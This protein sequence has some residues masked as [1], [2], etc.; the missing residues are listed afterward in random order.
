V[1]I[2]GSGSGGGIMAEQL[3]TAGFTVLV[4]EKGGYFQPHEFARW[5]ESEAMVNLYEKGG[6]SSSED[7]SVIVLAG[8]C[9]GG[10]TTVNWT[11][12]FRTPDVVQQDWANKGLSQFAKENG[13]FEKSLDYVVKRM[14]VNDKNSYYDED[15]K[16]IKASG[17]G[18]MTNENNTLLW[19][20]KKKFV[21]DNYSLL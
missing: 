10:G 21:E 2:V 8:S 17:K 9:V 14:G 16:D 11:A 18:F 4:L 1:V 15:E 12:S 20:V 5:R 13:D 3:V 6:L 19:K 7:G